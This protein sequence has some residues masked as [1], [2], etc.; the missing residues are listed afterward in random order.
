[1]TN[2]ENA[3]IVIDEIAVTMSYRI[4]ELFSAGLYS[5]PNKAFEELVSN[6]YDAFADSVSV[7]VDPDLTVDSAYIWVCDNGEGMDL[8]G[9]KDLWRVGYSNKRTPQRD[10][11]RLQI[12]CFG[13]GKL[14]TYVLANKLTYISKKS[15]LFLAVTMDYQRISGERQNFSLDA[16]ELTESE[17]QQALS[18]YLSSPSNSV[19][20]DLFGNTAPDSW[21][22]SI[23]TNLKPKAHEIREGRL[24]WVLRTALPINPGFKLYYNGVGLESS[25]INKP[26][27]KT[28]IIGENDEIANGI[29]GT[30]CR[31]ISGKYL[32][33][34]ENLKGVH[35]EIQLYEDS[36]VD[37]KSTLL[38][39]SHGI[40][41]MVRGR[42]I[43]IDD[44]LLGMDSFVHGVFNRTRIV[45]HADELDS[46]LTS[47]RESVK[48]SKPLS[49]LKSYIRKKFNNE[50]RK[51]YFDEE[52]KKQQLHQISHRLSQTSLT[53]S[54]RPLLVFAE[55]FFSGQISNPL[56]ID[57]P[58]VTNEEE[59]LELIR[60]QLS[61]DVAFIKEVDWKILRPSDR[62]ARFD[63]VNGKLTVNLLHPF[64]ANY[65]D[66]YKSRLP[67]QFVAIT[68]VLTE[69]HLY[70]LGLDEGDVN[71]IVLRRD[72][73][74]RELSLAHR[75]GS[76]AVAQ[77][78][79]DAL[80]DSTGLED[81][82]HGSLLSLGF[83]VT[84]IGG[85]GHPDGLAAAV[86]GYG[87]QGN[88]ASY[89]LTYDAK[90]TSKQKIQ[91]KTAGLA[92]VRNHKTD[93]KA[94]YAVVVA[95]DF[96]GSLDRN[97][98]ISKTCRQQEITAIRAKDLMRLLLLSVPK[99][100]GLMRLKGLLDSCFTPLEVKEWIDKVEG[101]LVKR[102]PIKSLLDA[103]Y[104]L[105]K[106]DTEPP[107]IASVRIHMK[108]L[109][110]ESE[111]PSKE[112]IRAIIESLQ[113][114]IPGF[115]SIE[116]EKVGIQGTPE[117]IVSVI[118]SV[119]SESIPSDL[120][121][122]YLEALTCRD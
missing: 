81:A 24:K 53:A 95:V 32:I 59:F 6:S 30:T 84:S 38:G 26:L 3:G 62:I 73:T 116:G 83:E 50:V 20:F 114:F 86:L 97:S 93:Y 120:R 102:A 70:E 46:N 85:R 94:D 17:A 87:S 76:P 82:V 121:E 34:F 71:G 65:I 36:M 43:N 10:S 8:Q 51:F 11:K 18:S 63:L 64:I 75:E 4:I 57:K 115:I 45:V 72:S 100:I 21:T 111:A 47:T 9:F 13:I 66:Q 118:S 92:A 56:L 40:F 5:S 101:D 119:V 54:K 67:L 14:A 78:L 42:L 52:N 108:N 55:K 58:G 23:L 109:D 29:D 117:K 7:H 107:E 110:P 105:Q 28:W 113:T 2:I 104:T 89:T 15:G 22:F 48:E 16:R 68:E 37:G 41:L 106:T 79:K 31:K 44:P 19:M 98:T 33:D 77:L 1:M 103:I 35:G 25:K 74:L 99:Q 91:A 61:E 60:S 39:R 12:G 80:A 122:M 90:S 27:V 96:E 88:S 49:Q 112:E 69:A